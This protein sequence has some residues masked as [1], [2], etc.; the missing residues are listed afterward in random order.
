MHGNL[1]LALQDLGRLDEAMARFQTALA[2]NPDF[3]EGHSNLGPLLL[4]RGDLETALAHFEQAVSLGPPRDRFTG[5]D[6]GRLGR[7]R[8]PPALSAE[9]DLSIPPFPARNAVLSVFLAR[10]PT[11]LAHDHRPYRL[12]S[13]KR[14]DIETLDPPWQCR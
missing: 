9:R 8:P 2:L 7:P 13:L 5:P 10:E 12:G 14:R 6:C 11:V 4:P 1:A 3:A